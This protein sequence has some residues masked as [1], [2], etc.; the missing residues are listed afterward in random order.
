MDNYANIYT[1]VINTKITIIHLIKEIRKYANIVDIIFRPENTYPIE[2]LKEELYWLQ[3]LRSHLRAIHYRAK[4]IR[5]HMK[6]LKE[7]NI[8]SNHIMPTV[9]NFYQTKKIIAEFEKVRNNICKENS[10]CVHHAH[11]KPRR[12]RRITVFEGDLDVMDLF[13]DVMNQ[14]F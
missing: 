6:T 11:T 12:K 9:H 4:I 5:M 2:S 3:N 8:V 7:K 10:S 14:I 13:Y 1:C